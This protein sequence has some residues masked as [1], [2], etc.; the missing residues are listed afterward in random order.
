MSVEHFD[1]LVVG[2]GLSGIG[3]GYHLKTRCPERSLAILEARESIGGTWDLFRYPGV[4]S[5]SDMFTLGYAFRPWKAGKAIADGASILEYIR[6]T[7]REFGIDRH[8]RFGHRIVSAA[9][10]S[11]HALWQLQVEV[12]GQLRGFTCN[13]LYLCSGYYRYDAGHLPAF[14]GIERFKGRLVHPQQWPQ[15][16]DYQ[17]KRIVVVGS[18]ATAVTLVPSLA[19][20]AA[21]VT[22]LQRSPSYV[23]SLPDTDALAD[24]LRKLLPEKLAHRL[25]RA[26]NVL[27]SM[28]LYRLCRHRPNLAKRLIRSGMRRYLG[29]GFPLD[30]HFAPSYQPWDQRLCLVPNGDLFRALRKGSASIVT[31]RIEGFSEHGVRLAS[32]Q[33]LAADIL[34]AATGLELVPCGGIRFEVDG[35]PVAVGDTYSYKGLMMS[36]LPNAAVCVGYTHLS[37]TLRADLASLYVCRLLRYMARKGYSHCV[38]QADD[39]RMPAAP[40]LDLQSGYILRAAPLFPKQGPGAPWRQ[41]QSYLGDLLDMRFGRLAQRNL[42]FHRATPAGEALQPGT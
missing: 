39:P 5:D 27:L 18:G 22:M 21:H 28:F 15:D 26:K 2:A 19:G 34:V 3:A 24:G 4:R 7:A 41:K 40:L 16:L 1:V 20:E 25:V 37:W 14:P 30:P 10:S 11:Q 6:D 32:G 9:W 12:G 13:F 35:R 17:G 36:G 33:E 8:I 29:E 23:L 42:K 38:A 31:D